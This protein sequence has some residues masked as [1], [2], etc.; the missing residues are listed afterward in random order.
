M[1]ETVLRTFA[2]FLGITNAWRQIAVNYVPSMKSTGFIL[3]FLLSPAIHP[4]VVVTGML[5]C[6]IICLFHW[7]YEFELSVLERLEQWTHSVPG[8]SISEEHLALT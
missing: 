4:A 7:G 8:E 2:Q 5:C 3:F 6:F 1:N